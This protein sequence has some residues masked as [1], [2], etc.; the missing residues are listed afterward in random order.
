MMSLA[1]LLGARDVERVVDQR[2]DTLDEA[3]GMRQAGVHLERPFVFPARVD[4]EQ[5]RVA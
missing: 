4:V 2:L 3:E 1:N 5:P